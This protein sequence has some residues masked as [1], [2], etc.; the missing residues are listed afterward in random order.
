MSASI[1]AALVSIV[2]GASAG[3]QPPTVVIEILENPPGPFFSGRPV[4]IR[5]TV[6]D[7]D[8][9]LVSAQLALA[10]QTM[11]MRPIVDEPAPAIRWIRWTANPYCSGRN[12]V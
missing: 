3:N 9:D 4:T 7:A 5:V 12:R 6:D 10:P 1:L 8:G 2:A 11:T